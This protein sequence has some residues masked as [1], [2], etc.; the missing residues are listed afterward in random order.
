MMKYDG[1]INS[2][3]STGALSEEEN[4]LCRTVMRYWANFIRTG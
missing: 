4:Q 3:E 2:L 1:V